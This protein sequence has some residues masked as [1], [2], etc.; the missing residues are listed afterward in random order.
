[1]L[2]LTSLST[3]RPTLKGYQPNLYSTYKPD[4]LILM[5]KKPLKSNYGLAKT[6]MTFTPSVLG[7]MY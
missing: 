1:M 5:A 6:E 2:V 7:F 4:H 3:V